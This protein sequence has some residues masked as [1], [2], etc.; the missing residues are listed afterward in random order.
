MAIEIDPNPAPLGRRAEFVKGWIEMKAAETG[1]KATAFAESARFEHG[2]LH[3]PVSVGDEGD[4]YDHALLLEQIEDNW[5]SNPPNE[6]LLIFIDPASDSQ[7]SHDT[8][9]PGNK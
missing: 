4:A 7:F 6:D 9:T 3:I 1:H 5:N 8:T 2:W